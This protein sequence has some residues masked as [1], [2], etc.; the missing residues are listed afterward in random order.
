MFCPYLV[1][2]QP[3]TGHALLGLHLVLWKMRGG[4]RQQ[5]VSGSPRHGWLLAGSVPVRRDGREGRGL[6]QR[7]RCGK[8]ALE[9]CYR[10]SGGGE[11]EELTP[12]RQEHSGSD[13]EILTWR[14]RHCNSAFFSYRTILRWCWYLRG[15]MVGVNSLQMTVRLL[16]PV[17]KWLQI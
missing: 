6:L 4:Q 1:I 14:V 13:E 5:V 7:R 16:K 12:G 11:D 10:W 2:L 17:N 15:L 3:G 9:V 8:H